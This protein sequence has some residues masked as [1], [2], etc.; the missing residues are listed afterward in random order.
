MKI[1]EELDL[2]EQI[3]EAYRRVEEG[4]K[5]FDIKTKSG[6]SIKAYQVGL[7]IRIDINPGE[8]VRSV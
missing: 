8:E 4:A 7:L 2:F 1:Y 5:R 3:E 6:L